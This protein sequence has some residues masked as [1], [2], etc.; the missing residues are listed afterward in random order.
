MAVKSLI[1]DYVSLLLEESESRLSR[2]QMKI[3]CRLIMD[4][5]AHVPDTLTRIRALPMVTVVGQKEPV[6]RTS[7]GNTILEVYVKFLPTSGNSYK[8][9]LSIAKLIKSLPSL[10]IV[11]VISLEGRPILFKGQPIVV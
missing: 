3:T 11:R 6:N 10:K 4:S 1:K 2:E 7:K 5:D 8:N 9:L